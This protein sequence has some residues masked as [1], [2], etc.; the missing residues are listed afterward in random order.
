VAVKRVEIV[1]DIDPPQITSATMTRPMGVGGPIEI[2]VS[3][4]D[5]SGLRQAAP[6]I[7]TVG[8]T[9]RRGFLRCDS[10]AGTC[11]E[12]LPPEAGALA[13]VEV[14]VEDYAGNLSK[15]P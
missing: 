8:V 2:V 14:A 12:S 4:Q 5:T 3:A 11:R 6:Y 7:V 1:H 10:A 9:E 13:I 15:R